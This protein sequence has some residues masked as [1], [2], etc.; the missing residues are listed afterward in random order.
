MSSMINNLI[1][2]QVAKDGLSCNAWKNS[3]KWK[4]TLMEENEDNMG[5]IGLLEVDDNTIR[6]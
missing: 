6:L 1:I 5:K 3:W 4:K 2:N